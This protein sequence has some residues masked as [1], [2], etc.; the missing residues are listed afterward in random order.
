M[1]SLVTLLAR[2]GKVRRAVTRSPRGPIP[3]ALMQDD[4]RSIAGV[5]MGAT[6]VRVAL[7]NLRGKVIVFL[8]Q[9]HPVH[10]DPQGTRVLIAQLISDCLARAGSSAGDL[11]GIGIAV[12]SPVDV[13]HPDR[14]SRLAMPAWEGGNGLTELHDRFHVPMLIDNDA[15]LGALAEHWWGV[16]RGVNDFSFIK[17]ASGVGAG[18]FID[19]R[20]Y[21]GAGGVAG[22]I[23]H[24]AIDTSG[25]QCGCGLR[26]CLTT[27][28]GERMPPAESFSL[29]G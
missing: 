8:E 25:S 26:G 3:A 11:I 23:G 17:L 10:D 4:A 28:I 13:R 12:P 1:E 29:S 22:E 20:I 27:L 7:T 5:D 19:G 2:V 15:N 24:M 6:H 9:R 18:H 21:R 14:L 16:G